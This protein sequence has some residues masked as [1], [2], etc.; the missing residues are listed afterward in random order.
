MFGRTKIAA[1]V[2][3]F[4]GTGALAAVI[5]AMFGRT[6][7]PFFADV[8]AGVT[9]GTLVLVV[10]AVS[11]GHF[12]PVV[13]LGLWTLRKIN[14]LQALVY[15]IAQMLGGLGVWA[16]LTYLINKPLNSMAAKNFEWR[17]FV[18]EALGTFIFT[19]GVAAAIYQGFEG[20]QLAAT[21]G[22][23][24][25]I[26]MLVGS[27][28]ANGLLNPAVAVGIQSWDRAYVLGPVAGAIVGM[29]LYAMLFA[30]AKSLL[31]AARTATRTAETKTTT[32]RAKTTTR[33]TKKPAARKRTTTRTRAR[34]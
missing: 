7:F 5:F 25:T 27:I 1:V 9:F 22:A 31:F 2:A 13:T 17:V 12:N 21:V 23:S 8:I 32:S 33:T 6:T 16:L 14:T 10:G 18:A 19:F 4:L 26:G 20:L 24:L 3:E 29:N 11:G 15:I 28:A 30:P 34:R